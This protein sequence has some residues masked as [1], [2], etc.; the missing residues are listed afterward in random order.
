MVLQARFALDPQNPGRFFMP[1]ARTIFRRA[2]S[3]AW[4]SNGLLEN[5]G[6]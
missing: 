3:R 6:L 1:M 5:R 2:H 4:E